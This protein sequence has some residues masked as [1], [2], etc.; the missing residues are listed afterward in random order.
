M[1]LF[2]AG[3]GGYGLFE[4]QIRARNVRAAGGG[5][6]HDDYSNHPLLE[7]NYIENEWRKFVALVMPPNA[8]EIQRKEMKRAFYAGSEAFLRVTLDVLEP[9]PEPTEND[10]RRMELISEELKQ[11]ATDVKEGRQ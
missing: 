5:G 7:M 6:S 10:M 1:R 8:P 3:S 11:F 9:G 2:S 4:K